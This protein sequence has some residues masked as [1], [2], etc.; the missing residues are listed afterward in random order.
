MIRTVFGGIAE[1]K[2]SLIRERTRAGRMAAVTRGVKF[3]RPMRA[4]PNRKSLKPSACTK[5]RSI[6]AWGGPEPLAIAILFRCYSNP[7]YGLRIQGRSKREGASIDLGAADAKKFNVTNRKRRQPAAF[8]RT[9][10]LY[11]YL[12]LMIL[13]I[14]WRRPRKSLPGSGENRAGP[15]C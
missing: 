10:A 6:D 8:S 1:F 2:R 11:S 4:R 3:G 9:R 15:F 14:L 13:L 12:I 7:H 5:Q